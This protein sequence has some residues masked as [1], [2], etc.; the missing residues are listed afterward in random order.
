MHK[1]FAMHKLVCSLSVV[2]LLATVSVQEAAAQEAEHQQVNQVSAE[3]AIDSQLNLTPEMVMYLQ[4]IRRYEDPK[5]AV[6][7]N[8]E[9]R[10]SARR[11]RISAMNWYG[12]SNSR[13]QASP[14]PF[15][16][17]YSPVWSGSNW[18]PYHWNGG[19]SNHTVFFPV[20][21]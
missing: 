8:A 20:P 3:Q 7:R 15:M 11:A 13:P 16:G 10:A 19:Y 6:R 9:Q 12:F 14:T 17:T 21:R 2:A 18:S 1:G 4:A 5:Q